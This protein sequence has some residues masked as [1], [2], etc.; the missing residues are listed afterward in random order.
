MP[1]AAPRTHGHLQPTAH[2]RTL[3]AVP[4]GVRAL[5]CLCG[6]TAADLADGDQTAVS[7]K[8]F[9]TDSDNIVYG[10]CLLVPSLAEMNKMTVRDEGGG[11]GGG[12]R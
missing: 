10:Y 11:G 12:L 6:G 4:R 3:A 1:C 9:G 8:L 5:F 7:V 2:C